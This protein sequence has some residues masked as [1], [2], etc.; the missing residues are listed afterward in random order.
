[1]DAD[2]RPLFGNYTLGFDYDVAKNQSL[3]ANARFGARN[4]RRMQ[5]LTTD[6]FE[7]DLLTGSSVRDVN[8]RDLSPSIDV[9]VDY[10]HTFKPQQSGASLPNTAV[11]N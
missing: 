11:T 1:M 10:L 8:G 7:N 2:D 4:F 9:N 6:L 5:H 3:T